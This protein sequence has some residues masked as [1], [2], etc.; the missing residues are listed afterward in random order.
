VLAAW[1]GRENPGSRGAVLFAGFW[2]N[3]LN[4]PGGPWSHPFQATDPV[5]T[6]Y[7][8]D[9]ASPAV[10]QTFGDALAQMRK[11]RQ[12]YG[13][14]LG[15]VQ[16]VLLDGQQIPLPGGPADPNGEFNAMYLSPPGAVPH[17]GSTY[18]Q[19]VGFVTR[20]SGGSYPQA[21]TVPAYS[22]SDNPASPYYDDQTKL[23]SHR[24][25]A[26]AYFSP[27]QVAAHAVST[28]VACGH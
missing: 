22:E 21:A 24:Q 6:P 4:L 9:T 20:A 14:A 8:L 10:R 7:G 13:I 28:T 1:N 23:F 16:Y 11:A 27:A 3:A 15:Q 2:G 25:W 18:I 17:L 26:T 19:A 5:H 12:P